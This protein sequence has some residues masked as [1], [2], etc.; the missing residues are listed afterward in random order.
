MVSTAMIIETTVKDYGKLTARVQE[1]GFK[2]LEEYFASYIREYG[3]DLVRADN[4]KFSYLMD[5][6]TETDECESAD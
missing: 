3:A 2:S 5:T 4:I 1:L 6:G